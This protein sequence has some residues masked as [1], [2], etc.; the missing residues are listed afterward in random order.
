MAGE[1]L[2]LKLQHINR[3]IC[4]FENLALRVVNQ[5]S[6][7][8]LPSTAKCLHRGYLRLLLGA[9]LLA[10]AQVP[11]RVGVD[12][13]LTLGAANPLQ[14]RLQVIQRLRN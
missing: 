4:R 3:K 7:P 1:E 12:H 10:Q 9:V 14:Q 5:D 11:P 13:P 8:S 2:H 6:N